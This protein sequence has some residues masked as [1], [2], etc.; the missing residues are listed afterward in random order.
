MPR[1]GAVAAAGRD[2]FWEARARERRQAHRTRARARRP[3]VCMRLE[4]WPRVVALAPRT[5]ARSCW[6]MA[7]RRGGRSRCR[8]GTRKR[9]KEERC[10]RERKSDASEKGCPYFYGR[11]QPVCQLSKDKEEILGDEFFFSKNMDGK[12]IWGYS[13][14]RLLCNLRTG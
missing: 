9:R 11:C 7:R 4:W 6:A 3:L 1:S 10:E 5:H 14:T 2:A 8:A 13:E 12:R